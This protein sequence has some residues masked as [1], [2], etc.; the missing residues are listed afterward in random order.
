MKLMGIAGWSGSGKTSLIVRLLAYFNEKNLRTSVIK[1]AHHN[2]EPDI[3]GKDSYRFRTEGAYQCCISSQ[4]I[5]MVVEQRQTKNLQENEP[6]LAELLARLKPCDLVIIE[7]F[8]FDPIIKCEIFNSTLNKPYLYENDSQIQALI[9]DIIPHHLPN[10]HNKPIFQRDD[11]AQIGEFIW[12][13]AQNTSSR[14]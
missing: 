2:F 3:I 11:I 13:N 4:K 7:G 10:W 6:N 9:A 14:F 8:K 1:H 12:Q 5:T